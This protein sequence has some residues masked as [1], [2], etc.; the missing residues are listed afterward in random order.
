MPQEITLQFLSEDK[1]VAYGVLF[2]PNPDDPGN[3]L[4]YENTDTSDVRYAAYYWA[5]GPLFVQ[6][7]LPNPEISLSEEAYAAYFTRLSLVDQ[8]RFKPPVA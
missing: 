5:Q 3:S 1:N 8:A 7:P 2:A 6:P 4:Y